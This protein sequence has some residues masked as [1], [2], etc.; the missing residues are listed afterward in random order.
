MQL[1]GV[2]MKVFMSYD[3][4]EDRHYKELLR[5]WDANTV[6]DFEFDHRSPNEAINRTE[7]VVIKQ[8]LTRMMKQAEYLLV[9]I[10]KKSHESKWIQWEIDRAKQ[11]DIKLQLA[12]IKIENSFVTPNGLIGVGTSFTKAF[13][14]DGIVTALKNA[15]NKY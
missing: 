10:G 13:T 15:N 3:H 9:I 2:N 11:Q 5:A 1:N 14:K 8:S 12:A 6:F 7:A 4:S